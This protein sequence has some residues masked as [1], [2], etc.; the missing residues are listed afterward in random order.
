M[1]DYTERS[2]CDEGFIRLRRQTLRA[3]FADGSLSAPFPYDEVQRSALDAVV[4]VP[5]FRHEDGNDHVFLR[6]ALRPPVAL[7]SP[8]V[9]PVPERPSLGYLWEVPAGLVEHDERSEP[10]LRQCA[11][12]EL[13]EEVGFLLPPEAMVPLGPPNFPAPSLIGERHFF[14]HCVVVPA[15]CTTPMGDGSA[16]EA[17]ATVVSIPLDHAIELIRLGE[18]EDAKTE[19]ALRRLREIIP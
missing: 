9:W 19:I 16:L 17:I 14:F 15:A 12:R 3:R 13:A 4:V 1:E 10:G 8:D 18:I 5:H 2:R 11:A 6:T 7:R